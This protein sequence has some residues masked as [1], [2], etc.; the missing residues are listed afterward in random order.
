MKRQ[1]I[2]N[3]SAVDNRAYY[4]YKRSNW[5]EKSSCGIATLRL[6]FDWSYAP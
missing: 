4:C 6:P 1:D 2:W 5:R 3:V